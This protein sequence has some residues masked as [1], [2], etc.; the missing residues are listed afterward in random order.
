MILDIIRNIALRVA[1]A[2]SDMKAEDVKVLDMRSV[3]PIADYFVICSCDSMVHLRAVTREILEEVKGD[4]LRVKRREGADEA[5]WILVDLGDVI[6]HVFH[7][8]EREFYD[9]DSLWADAAEVDWKAELGLAQDG[10]AEQTA[11]REWAD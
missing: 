7:H 11:A 9:L 10:A 6:V 4:N 2:A 5:R 8:A 3:S 1:R